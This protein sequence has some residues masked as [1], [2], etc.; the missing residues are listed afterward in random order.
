MCSLSCIRGSRYGPKMARVWTVAFM[1]ALLVHSAQ[2]QRTSAPANFILGDS[3]VDP[4]NNNY[5]GTLAKSNFPP[6]GI[7]FQQGATG[8]FCNGRTVA[9]VIVQLAN[10]PFVPAYLDPK[11]RGTAILGG[12]NYASAAGGI[13]DSTGANYIGRISL[14]QQLQY[15]QKTQQ[16]FAQ[17]LGPVGAQQALSKALYFFVIGSNDYINNYLLAG[18]QTARQ[19]TPKQYEALLVNEFARQITALYN[20][21]ARKIAV[22]NVGPLGCIPSQLANQRSVDGSC[23][24]FINDYV[25]GFNRALG[26]KLND[27]ATTLTGSTLVYGN[28]YDLVFDKVVNP[29]RYGLT[30]VNQGCCGFGRFNGQIPCITGLRPC[31]NRAQYL[32]W[33][34]FHPT[35]AVNVQLGREFFSGGLS[36]IS[37]VNIQQLGS[38]P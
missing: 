8:R 22:F 11:S 34:P 20:F 30:V 23:I 12:L 10:Q 18:S 28:S 7:D 21:G 25:Q 27:L 36:S 13:L 19:Y 35:D 6:N 1:I 29:Q 31:A 17:L 2:S 4:G 33:D 26:L 24:Q 37:P 9:D 38:L 14:N 32:F 16:E 15:F 5:I 3:L